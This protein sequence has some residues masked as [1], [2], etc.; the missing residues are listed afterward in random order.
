MFG[1]S[2]AN[3]LAPHSKTRGLQFTT[4]QINNLFF[5]QTSAL[6]DLFKRGAILPRIANDEGDLFWCVSRILAGEWFKRTHCKKMLGTVVASNNKSRALWCLKWATSVENRQN[7]PISSRCALQK[8]KC[9][10]QSTNPPRAGSLRAQRRVA[11]LR[12][13]CNRGCTRVEAFHS[14]AAQLHSLCG[15]TL[16]S[17]FVGPLRHWKANSSMQG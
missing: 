1:D 8:L 15:S 14:I 11:L 3:T 7:A 10:F 12:F 5:G 2:S 9:N 6:L 13:A 16:H 4:H 17:G